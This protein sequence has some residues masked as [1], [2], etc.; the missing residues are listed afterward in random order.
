M[1]LISAHGLHFIYFVYDGIVRDWEK[2]M[3]DF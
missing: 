3:S 2:K 1:Q